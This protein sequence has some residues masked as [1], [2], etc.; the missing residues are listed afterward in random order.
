MALNVH[1]D[2]PLVKGVLLVS[3]VFDDDFKK[4][5][6][7]RLLQY[8]NGEIDQAPLLSGATIEFLPYPPESTRLVAAYEGDDIDQEELVELTESI[9]N[10]QSTVVFCDSA[11]SFI[12]LN[13]EAERR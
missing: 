5:V 3:G 9:R 11:L 13:S 8:L 12:Y 7:T 2:E 4:A 1:R 6:R 10:R